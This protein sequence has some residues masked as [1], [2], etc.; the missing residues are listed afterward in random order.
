MSVGAARAVQRLHI[1][2]LLSALLIMCAMLWSPAAMAQNCGQAT[3]QGSA[4]AS[5]QTYCWLNLANYNDA[6]A[7]TAAG[8]NLSFTLSDGSVLTF[9]ARVTGTST[10]YN[11]IAAP[12]W[13]GSAIGNSAFIGI[14][15]RP[16]LYTASA[17]TRTISL[18]NIT[19]TPPVGASATVF[20]FVVADAESSNEG[21]TLRMVTNGG[22][23]QLLDSVQPISGSN[24]PAIAGVGTSS[25]SISGRSGTVGAYIL[26]S[27]S[28]TSVTVET[29][30][31]GLQGVMFAV[32]FATIR[33]ETQISTARANP[34]DQ[35][36]YRIASGQTGATLTSGTTSGSGG[37]PFT[38]AP[39]TMSAGMSLSLGID[40]APGSPSS[41]SAYASSLTCVN[42]A[43][44]T[45]AALPANLA[46]TS[47]NIGQLQFGEYLVCTF[48]VGAHPRLQLRK[49]L[50]SNGR[51]FSGDQFTIRIRDGDTVVASRTTSGSGGTVN[52]GDTGLVQVM[53]GVAYSVDE[54][55]A[56]N[57]MLINYD[58]ALA[59]NN[60]ASGSLT[61]LPT[62]VGGT[63]NPRLGDV[64][65]CTITNTRSETAELIVEK[66]SIVISDPVNGTIN[67]KLIPGAIVEYAIT[68]RNVGAGRPDTGGITIIDI[69]PQG[70]AFDATTP[71]TFVNGSPSSGLSSFSAS[72]MVRFS[73]ASNGSEPFTYTPVG[74]FD[75][76]VR[77]I[78]IIPGGRM[79]AASASTSQPNFTIRFRARVQ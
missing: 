62:A 19:V 33:L 21:E 39:L 46:V 59:C 5:W 66:S 9:N 40:M 55:A 16:V 47:A 54:I 79:N 50:G 52:N 25:V 57:T 44:T 17:G 10:A 4:P 8:Q 38:T 28:P 42:T 53:S 41:L 14:P 63:V 61:A 12:S 23:W 58:A 31:G 69:M 27:N 51:R 48:T 20:S 70:M 67:P 26:S 24:F 11:A 64:I 60:G 35:L 49:A 75:Q 36:R 34:S 15:G 68:V 7:R 45:R 29:Q 43:G 71:V 73:S 76:N 78:R 30:A 2:H 77:G 74:P 37:G 3:I 13:N 6:A 1:R 56:G 22:G 65:V 72:S 18:S 32:R